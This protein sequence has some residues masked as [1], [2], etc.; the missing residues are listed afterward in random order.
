MKNFIFLF[1]LDS[2]ITKVEILPKI[3]EIIGIEDKMRSLTES[4]MKG[5][6]PFKVNFLERVALLKSI[7]VSTVEN[8]VSKIEL[9]DQIVSFIQN[10][11]DRC[12]I[13]TG[14]LDV[15]ITGLV[16][17]IGLENHV[18]CSKASVINNRISSI[19]SVIDK[20]LMAKQ[21]VQPMVV[22]GD[23]DNDS[24]MAKFAKI[25]IGYGGVRKIAPSLL[26][27]VDFAFYNSLRLVNFL[28]YLKTV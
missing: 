9:D 23:G 20:E 12:F 6:T 7:E 26:R 27:N 22:I 4:G 13:L 19:I 2:T 5:E 1:D 21:I 3:S 14:N 15:W 28:N 11:K 8:C 18:F 16:K 24:G 10:N 25:A 17:R